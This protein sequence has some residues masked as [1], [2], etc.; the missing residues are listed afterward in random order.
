MKLNKYDDDGIRLIDGELVWCLK[1]KE[2]LTVIKDYG[3]GEL[4]LSNGVR[5]L[6]CDIECYI[7]KPL[8]Q[9]FF[10]FCTKGFPKDGDYYE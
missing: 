2:F 1:G 3:N 4:D 10:E 9:L 6:E 8:M 7:H 5:V